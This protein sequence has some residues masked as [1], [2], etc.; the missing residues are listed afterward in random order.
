MDLSSKVEA[1][2]GV[3]ALAFTVAMF[4]VTYSWADPQHGYFSYLSADPEPIRTLGILLLIIAVLSIIQGFE[5][6]FSEMAL[7]LALLVWT[8]LVLAWFFPSGHGY[9]FFVLVDVDFT[10]MQL[11]SYASI[12]IA[13]EI[14]M[15]AHG[16]YRGKKSEEYEP[17]EPTEPNEHE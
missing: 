7:G 17:E 3:F 5:T 6:S 9:N 12:G 16:L 13:L 4:L 10:Y 8:I 14:A 2:L 1:L 15:I 11:I